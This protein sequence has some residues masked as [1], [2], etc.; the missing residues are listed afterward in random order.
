MLPADLIG[1]TFPEQ[2]LWP[3]VDHRHSLTPQ[4]QKDAGHPKAAGGG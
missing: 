2:R 1:L 4:T 3:V